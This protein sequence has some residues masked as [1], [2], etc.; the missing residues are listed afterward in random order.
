MALLGGVGWVAAGGLGARGHLATAAELFGQLQQQVRRGDVAAAQGTLTAL[1]AET[2]AA[3]ESTDSVGWR[4]G[5]HLPVVGDDLIAVHT[6][7][8]VLDDLAVDGLPALL[9]VAGRLEPSALAPRD[10]RVDLSQLTEAA[11]QIASGLAA[12]RRARAATTAIRTD[13]LIGQVRDAVGRLSDGLAQ[14]ER[15]VGVADRAA[16]LLPAMLGARGP[17]DYLVLFQNNAEVRATGGMPGAYVVVHADDGRLSI[18]DQGTATSDLKIFEPPVRNLTPEMLALYTDRPAVF[19]ADV[20]LTPDFPTAARLAREMYRKRSGLAVNGVLA[21][22]PVALSYLLR[23]TG[24]VRVP[25]GGSLTADNAVRM[26]LS[27]A[28]AKYPE[29]SDQ[30]AYFARAARAIFNTL[31]AHPGN[32]EGMIAQLARAAGERR[33][34]VWS[35]VPAEEEQLTG[36]VLGGRLPVDDVASPTVGVFLNDGGGSKLSY[37][38]TEAA[39]LSAG[40]CTD[41]GA[42][43][44]HLE[45][46]L[47]SVA[48]SAGLPSYVTGLAL[49]GH[50]Y[51][52]RTNVMIFSST[53]GGVVSATENG[54]EVS[55]GSGV[56]GDR[57]VG[58]F[59]VDLP[60]GKRRT[61]EVT[62]RTASGAGSA[63]PVT[64]RLWTTPTVRP[65]S[66]SVTPAG[67][68]A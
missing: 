4:V 58:V 38:L 26:L 22:D 55:F 25:K 18:T 46:T 43:E 7:A 24:A 40:G 12:I 31:L 53:G 37:Y 36:T 68:C 33:L 17:R 19:P 15:L 42:R 60:P 64:P 13:D 61:L 45:L 28:Y 54:K 44:L 27:T 29:P 39:R 49:S 47:G 56:E 10:G 65:W 8:A 21:T 6:V 63:G 11:P 57:M 50:P 1:R 59:T 52:S 30:D 62:L 9:A 32:A 23:V 16:R 41:D 51:T 14:A 35:A 3:R 66:E 34:L 48:P 20:N 67:D 2:R 5:G